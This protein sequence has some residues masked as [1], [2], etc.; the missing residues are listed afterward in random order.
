MMRTLPVLAA[1]IL[2][3]SGTL[4]LIY[5][6][7]LVIPHA[8]NGSLFR[9]IPFSHMEAISKTGC[10][11]YGV[12]AIAAGV[13][14]IW[15]AFGGSYVPLTDRGIAKSI[16]TTKARVEQDFGCFDSCTIAQIEAS[17]R[18]SRVS[19]KHLPYLCAAFMGKNEFDQ[20]RES[21][22]DVDW[23]K[24]EDRVA[25]IACELPYKE[26]SGTHFHETWVV[27]VDK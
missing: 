23:G 6:R 24:I 5:P 15:G 18:T 13:F 4:A 21:M 26:L 3:V 17:V 27:T 9:A 14:M 7:A 11:Y 19:P 10:Q 2:I 12:M 1:L 20:L 22:P 8:R 16:V 25:R